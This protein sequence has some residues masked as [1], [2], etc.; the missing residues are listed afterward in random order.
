M[1]SASE[2][3][4]VSIDTACSAHN[5]CVLV[6]TYNNAGTL[7]RLLEELGQYTHH[8]VVVNDGST[9]G[10]EKIIASFPWIQY[11]GYA[12][13]R[14][15]GWA[16]RKGFDFARSLGYEQAITID[17]DGQHYPHDLV[18]FVEAFESTGEAIY[19]GQRNMDQAN[20]PGKSS[21]GNRFSNFW[22]RL[23][24]GIKLEDTQSGYRMYPLRPL[25]RIG[26]VTRKYEFEVEVMVRAAWRG[27]PVLPVKVSVYYPPPDQRISHFRPLRDFTRISVLNTFLCLIAVF[28]YWPKRLLGKLVPKGWK[29]QLKNGLVDPSE[30]QGTKVLSVAVGLFMGIVPIWGFQLVVAILI[31]FMLKLN[32]PLV[33]L[34]ANISIPPMIP[35]ILYGSYRMGALWL[36]AQARETGLHMNMTLH[37]I[38][39]N[40]RQY[41]FGSFTLAIV[42]ALIGALLTYILIKIFGGGS[43]SEPR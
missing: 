6:P 10:T 16:L 15:K 7:G 33:V 28:W 40:L 17:S 37:D 31:A 19:V 9:D 41:I 29:D 14:G 23:F 38:T 13:N 12:Q 36:P 8:V 34:A 3:N 35:L 20:V 5:I 32:K 22:F 11:T 25:S 26:F 43:S 24:T 18:R 21:F 27:V 30:S 39:L 2:M 1:Q 4:P 42:A